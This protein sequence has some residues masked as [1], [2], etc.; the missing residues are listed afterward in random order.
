MSNKGVCKTA[1]AT[2]GLLYSHKKAKVES[3]IPVST[4]SQLKIILNYTGSAPLITEAQPTR[5]TNLSKK[6]KTHNI[7][8]VTY[9]TRDM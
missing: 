8:T 5:F 4:G 7:V 6:N 3:V 9:V 2:P 1:P